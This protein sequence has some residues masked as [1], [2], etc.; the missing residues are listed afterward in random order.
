VVE[1]GAAGQAL[2]DASSA[3]D[4]V[5]VGIRVRGAFRGMVLGSVSHATIHGT[6]CPV[7]VIGDR[8][9]QDEPTELDMV[10]I[11]GYGSFPASDPPANW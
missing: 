10:D 5:V 11:W 2:V 4:L 9:A 1:H 8:L 7:A 6:R 3:A